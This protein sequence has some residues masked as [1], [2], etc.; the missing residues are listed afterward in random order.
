MFRLLA[1]VP[2]L[3][4]LLGVSFFNRI[5]PTV[6]GIPLVLAWQIGCVFLTMFTMALIYRLDPAN[7]AGPASKS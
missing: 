4:I 7:K 1:V 6:S 2:V 5:T 3:A